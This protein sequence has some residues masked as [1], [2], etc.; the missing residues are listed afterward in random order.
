MIESL[1]DEMSP[2]PS[3]QE[4]RSSFNFDPHPGWFEFAMLEVQEEM[5]ENIARPE[6]EASYV[7]NAEDEIDSDGGQIPDIGFFD[8]VSGSPGGCPPPADEASAA[9]TPIGSCRARQI[10]RAVRSKRSKGVNQRSRLREQRL[11][12]VPR[13]ADRAI[14][15]IQAMI[16]DRQPRDAMFDFDSLSDGSVEEP[17]PQPSRR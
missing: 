2:L 4:M 1:D 16:D 17:E 8:D 3:E 10:R 7:Y 6:Y 15:D 11:R 12:G 14:R 13:R 9:E 5:T